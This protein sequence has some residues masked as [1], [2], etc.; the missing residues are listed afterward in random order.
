MKIFSGLLFLILLLTGFTGSAEGIRLPE[1]AEISHHGI[2]DGRTW[3]QC[4]T[5]G[6]TYAAARKN[7][8]WTLRRQ[9]WVKIKTVDFDRIHWKSLEVWSKGRD[10][11]LLQYWRAEVSLTGFAWGRLKNGEKS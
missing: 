7:F 5:I 4:G 8:D 6:L 1:G 2:P 3:E 10:K 11:I 9:G